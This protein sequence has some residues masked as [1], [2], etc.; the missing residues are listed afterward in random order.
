M[1]RTP[2]VIAAMVPF[3]A[4]AS[5]DA[6]ETHMDH[7]QLQRHVQVTHILGAKVHSD[8]GQ[9]VGT[10]QD[11]LFDQQGN[12]SSVLLQREDN[13]AAEARDRQRGEA[14]ADAEAG[15]AVER[16]A[17]N[18]SAVTERGAQAVEEEWE[19]ATSE[20]D[21]GSDYAD[22]REGELDMADV[23]AERRDRTDREGNGLDMLGDPDRV[24]A[25][26]RDDDFVKVQWRDVSFS[27]ED[28]VLRMSGDRRSALQAVQY[29]QSDAQASQREVRASELIGLEVNLADEDSFGEVEDVMV[30][31]ENGKASALVVDSME[32]FDK[33]RYALPVELQGLNS[34]DDALTL[35]LTQQQVEDMGEFEMD[36]AS[37]R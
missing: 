4:I 35:R 16:G 26:E 18:A 8:D 6:N 19:E 2:L 7:Q 24:D 28:Q 27:A 15:N 25:A 36:A 11:I 32:F 30:D 10:V 31:P 9:D 17:D 1:K 13:L 20:G 22:S 37:N 23:R 21:A 12:V 14:D 34:E 3:V 29:E 33:E 5:Q